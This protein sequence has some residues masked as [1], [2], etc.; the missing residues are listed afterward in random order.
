MF[1]PGLGR[2]RAATGSWGAW[3][4]RPASPPST[5]SGRVRT[6]DGLELAFDGLLGVAE[7]ASQV[8]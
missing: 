8:W 4:A 2:G 1:W 7:E 5:V 3:S 6:D